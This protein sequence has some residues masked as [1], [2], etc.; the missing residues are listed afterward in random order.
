[1]E[2]PHTTTEMR[3]VWFHLEKRES[4]ASQLHPPPHSGLI[5]K[6]AYRK[7]SYIVTYSLTEWIPQQIDFPF[8][9]FKVCFPFTH[10]RPN[11]RNTQEEKMCVQTFFMY[12]KP[13]D[14]FQNFLFTFLEI[15]WNS[16]NEFFMKP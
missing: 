5:D 7:N 4:P 9:I 12:G 10:E 8:A 1:M 15:P 14:P 16:T 6:I 13:G 3:L 11:E 2:K